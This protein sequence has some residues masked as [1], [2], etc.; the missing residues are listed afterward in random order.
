MLLQVPTYTIRV[1]CTPQKR[2]TAT[3]AE[4]P[5]GCRRRGGYYILVVLYRRPRKRNCILLWVECRG[6]GGGWKKKTFERV[7]NGAIMLYIYVYIICSETVYIYTCEVSENDLS[8]GPTRERI[9]EPECVA[10][11]RALKRES[12]TVINGQTA[13]LLA[14]SPLCRPSPLKKKNSR[15][16]IRVWVGWFQNCVYWN[17]AS[18]CYT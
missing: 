16:N 8:D 17:R 10:H 2:K 14:H 15:N 18:R 7:G 9:Y 11:T 1:M 3:C 4:K 6:G 13:A 12:R 5:R